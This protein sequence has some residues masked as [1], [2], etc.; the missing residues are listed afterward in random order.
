MAEHQI[1]KAI[2]KQ[3]KK[4]RLPFLAVLDKNDWKDNIKLE[5]VGYLDGNKDN[6]KPPMTRKLTR[7]PLLNMLEL[8]T[9]TLMLPATFI[10]IF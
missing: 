5:R 6:S 7:L 8:F 3:W 2:E 4:I 9:Y 10:M 1:Q